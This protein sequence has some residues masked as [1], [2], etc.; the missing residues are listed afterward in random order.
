[1]KLNIEMTEAEVLGF[2]KLF[3]GS[4]RDV[5]AAVVREEVRAAQP[6][7]PVAP[8]APKEAV[9][10]EADL[11]LVEKGRVLFADLVHKWLVN[12]GLEGAEQPDRIAALRDVASGP[13]ATAV[14]WYVSSVGGLIHAVDAIAGPKTSPHPLTPEAEEGHRATVRDVATNIA[15]VSSLFFHDLCSLYEHRDIYKEK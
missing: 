6:P 8:E 5:Q 7:A 10:T 1:M 3:E 15:Q 12:F 11:K 9:V 4:L 2:C 14:L 13:E